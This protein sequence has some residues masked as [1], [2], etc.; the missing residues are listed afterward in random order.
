MDIFQMKMFRAK[1][2]V[3][4]SYWSLCIFL[5]SKLASYVFNKGMEIQL[6]KQEPLYDIIQQTFP[7]LQSIRFLPEILHVVPVILLS[8][9]VALYRHIQCLE[10]F[11]IK[12][13][14]LMLIRGF[15]FSAT[16]LPDSSQ[17]CHLSNHFGGC[18]DLIFSGHST[19][20]FLSTLLLCQYFPIAS[21]WKV[22]LH[23]N[24][25]ITSIMIILCRNHY[26]ID[27]LISLM[28]TYFIWRF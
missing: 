20:M 14:S 23:A 24:N 21:Q 27:V 6:L 13:G 1:F 28:L 12:H 7:N 16:L 8:C 9:Y 15:C 11:M 10:S 25:I 22:L 2:L 19:I 3:F 26:T 17:M 4:V 18:F 5:H